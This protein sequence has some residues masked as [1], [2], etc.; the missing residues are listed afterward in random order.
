MNYYYVDKG[1]LDNKLITALPVLNGCGA[2]AHGGC[3]C[4]GFCL[5]VV[6][7]IDRDKYEQFLANY[8]TKEEFLT[9]NLMKDFPK[10]GNS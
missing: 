3:G 5:N 4:L 2:A 1:D 6:G 8:K 10:D 9:E 7:Y